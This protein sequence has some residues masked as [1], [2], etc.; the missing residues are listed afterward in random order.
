MNNA[1]H[2]WDFI[3]GDKTIDKADRLQEVEDTLA[4]LEIYLERY[5]E[6]DIAR[7]QHEQYSQKLEALAEDS[8]YRICKSLACLD[9]YSCQ[10][11]ATV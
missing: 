9:N 4:E 10:Q 3:P 5:P 2:I 8:V 6:D 11:N 7:M 1:L